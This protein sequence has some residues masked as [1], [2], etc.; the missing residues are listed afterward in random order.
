MNDYK[1]ASEWLNHFEC[2]SEDFLSYLKSIYG[3]DE[4]LI[5][6]KSKKFVTVLNKHIEKY[7]DNPVVI[8]RAPGRINLMGRHVEHRGGNINAISIH[9][10]TIMV[11]SL[12]DDDKVYISNV[13]DRFD[14]FEFSISEEKSLC[15]CNDW[16]DYIESDAVKERVAQNRGHWVNYVKAAVLRFG[17]ETGK[18]IRG[19]NIMCLGTIPVAGGVSSSSS[20]VVATAEL[21]CN[22]NDFDF[23]LSKFIN[24]CGQAEWYVGSRGGAGDHAAIKCGVLD[25]ISPI[26]FEPIKF[27]GSIGIPEGYSIIV[28]NSFIEA[29]KSEGAKDKFNQMV[30][31]YEFGVMMIKKNYP[32]YAEKIKHLR[33]I[34]PETLGVSEKKIYEMLLSIPLFIKP[35]ELFNEINEE[36][37]GKVNAILKTHKAPEC[38]NLRSAVLYGIAECERS[39]MCSVLLKTGKIDD[40]AEIMNISHDGDRV[41]KLVD[42]KIMD[43]DYYVTD[44]QLVELIKKCDKG[45]DYTR[46]Y[47]QPGG[48]GC[49]TKEI[50]I[51]IDKLLGQKGVLSAQISGAGLGGCI[52][53]V[54]EKANEIEILNYLKTEYYEPNGFI[55]GAL[56]VR[57]ITGSMCLKNNI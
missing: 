18:E 48:Y 26:A 35:E 34:N 51:L 50:D 24:L 8:V 6:R 22:V 12:R 49:S 15:Y 27:L 5:D 32:E 44:E 10:E 16:L 52:M 46:L 37:H 31:A 40:F 1:K 57:P 38:Y 29:K 36:F 17:L 45:K 25:S 7:G 21:V 2:I 3:N 55:N 47:K 39:R 11:A 23:E 33:D 9:K 14:D 19:M 20:I 13:S 4:S 56:I 53:I 54:C 41:S 43:Y 42:G 28:A 30:A